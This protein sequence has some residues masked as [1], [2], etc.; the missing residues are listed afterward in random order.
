MSLDLKAAARRS[1]I[2]MGFSLVAGLCAVAGAIGYFKFHQSWAL[3]AF[4]GAV[5]VGLGSQIWFIASLRA[6]RSSS[7]GKGA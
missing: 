3:A 6:P 4:L 1:S 2:M 5:V 7:T